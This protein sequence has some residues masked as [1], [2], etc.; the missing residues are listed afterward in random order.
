MN[1]TENAVLVLSTILFQRTLCSAYFLYKPMSGFHVFV[2]IIY[3]EI[4]FYY[5]FYFTVDNVY[6]TH[7]IYI[8]VYI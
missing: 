7:Y 3:N 2:L 6:I 1:E 4:I 8:Y 5:I